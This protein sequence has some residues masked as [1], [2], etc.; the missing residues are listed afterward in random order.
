MKEDLETTHLILREQHERD[1][2]KIRNE[3]QR[4]RKQVE[5]FES[6]VKTMRDAVFAPSSIFRCGDQSVHVL[7]ECAAKAEI[8]CSALL[9]KTFPTGRSSSARVGED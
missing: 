2:N 7:S 3:P 8:P 5:K 1:L 6:A 9:L 4:I